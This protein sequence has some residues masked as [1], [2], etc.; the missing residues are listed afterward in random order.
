MSNKKKRSEDIASA[1]TSIKEHLIV[2]KPLLHVPLLPNV[3]P[4]KLIDTLSTIASQ[5]SSLSGLCTK[6]AAS[7]SSGGGGGN[8]EGSLELENQDFLDGEGVLIWNRSGE[9]KSQESGKKEEVFG[10]M[11]H[12]AFRLIE[13]GYDGVVDATGATRLLVL[14][15]K[16]GAALTLAG[17]DV[18]AETVLV[19]CAAYE[20]QVSHLPPSRSEGE[21]QERAKAVTQYYSARTESMFQKGM[22]EPA[23]YMFKQ[24]T[25]EHRLTLITAKDIFYLVVIA[26]EI[27]NHLLRPTPDGE[28]LPSE[29]DTAKRGL[30]AVEWLTLA[31]KLGEAAVR[32][33]GQAYGAGKVKRDT[34]TS[35]ALA[36]VLSASLKP[37]NLDSA[38]A[39]LHE[40]LTDPEILQD[41]KE[42][43]R[44]R[45]I[46]LDCVRRRKAGDTKVIEA[47]KAII[48]HD[49][50]EEET[51]DRVLRDT[52]HSKSSGSRVVTISVL[53]CLLLSLL[54]LRPDEARLNSCT[55]VLLSIAIH[56]KGEE[57]VERGCRDVK[58]AFDTVQR[59][60]AFNPESA[61]C[62]A[63][64]TVFWQMGDRAYNAVPPRYAEAAKC[65]DLGLHPCLDAMK[66]Y[67]PKIHR[68]IALCYIRLQ[69]YERA[70]ERIKAC[71][72]KESSTHYLRFMVFAQQ[73]LEDQAIAALQ[74]MTK[75]DDMNGRQL[76]LATQLANDASLANVI[77]ASLGAILNAIKDGT[78]ATEDIAVFV[79]L[80]CLIRLTLKKIEDTSFVENLLERNGLIDTLNSQYQAAVSIA[81]KVI[82]GKDNPA[83]DKE[84]SWLYKQA[85]NAAIRG[86]QEGWVESAVH[87]LFEAAVSFMNLY[88][89][90]AVGSDPQLPWQRA[91]GS[92]AAL[93]SRTFEAK[94]MPEGEI[95][96]NA[97]IFIARRAAKDCLGYLHPLLDA[98]QMSP[99]EQ[100]ARQLKEMCQVARVFQVE[101][102][103]A[104]REW[105]DAEVTIQEAA[106]RE[107]EASTSL[108][109]SL[110]NVIWTNL[111]CPTDV[112][113]SVLESLLRSSLAF[114][115]LRS[116]DKF[117]RWL[118]T[119]VAILF[120][121]GGIANVEKALGYVSQA[122]ELVKA[123]AGTPQ[124]Y[125]QEEVDWLLSM[126]WNKGNEDYSTSNFDRAK[127]WIECSLGLLPFA[128]SSPNS[129][130]RL[131]TRYSEL[132]SK[133][134][135]R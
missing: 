89:D 118:R 96:R 114:D 14:G 86:A 25:D 88:A 97:M 98:A 78:F 109:E 107:N 81:K 91:M 37:E 2:L 82:A 51:V 34:M 116:V 123:Q 36:F 53:Q 67:F 13:A 54:K 120:S 115:F 117:S 17:K 79:L 92:F 101:A 59:W 113:V 68:K 106:Q 50:L 71:P 95:K 33:G 63:Y 3:A 5:A 132:L 125:P 38:E 7:K 103:C 77:I 60:P 58:A 127:Q 108:F 111:D 22:L 1:L 75:C 26:Q 24:A 73:G 90:V 104:L 29:N 52:M 122:A 66:T 16:A 131:K 4:T 44:T 102:F 74:A 49:D 105:T 64:Q 61:S 121:R 41:K 72:W 40:L 48:E 21:S 28:E 15:S 133:M 39:S 112:L 42:A 57:N 80:R 56:A 128:S 35:L 32:A 46:L 83:T 85:Y 23:L 93:C 20:E 30:D 99:T 134:A 12:A 94:G 27:G 84:L 6:A 100:R 87:G 45:W 135:L 62:A 69:D 31:M 43:S 10:A 126:S 119:V 65:Y 11:R 55:K 19:K 129:G 124:P 18:E 110:S 70:I 8:R 47:F 76:I 9:Y 130:Q